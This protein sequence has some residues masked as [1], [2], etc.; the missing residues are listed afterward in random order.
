VLALIP[1]LLPLAA[2]HLIAPRSYDPRGAPLYHALKAKVKAS[3]SVDLTRSCRASDTKSYPFSH[4]PH[5]FMALPR[6]IAG[7]IHQMRSGSSYLAAHTSWHDQ[8]VSTLCPSCEEEDESFEHA[9][10]HCPA[11]SQQRAAHLRDVTELGPGAPVWSSAPLILGLA[12][13][14]SATATG[15]PPTMPA[16]RAD[17]AS[18]SGSP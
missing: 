6:F 14:I 2:P 13:Y 18:S 3:A 11:K 5:P 8:G 16:I 7:R 1:T 12:S 15:F 9:I 17:S 4:S 10:L